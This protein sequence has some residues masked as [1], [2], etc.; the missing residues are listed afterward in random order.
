ME[1]WLGWDLS[2]YKIYY[3]RKRKKKEKIGNLSES[4]K[5]RNFTYGVSYVGNSNSYK[6]SLLEGVGMGGVYGLSSGVESGSDAGGAG[7]P[8]AGS[9]TGC[10]LGLA[11]SGSEL[12]GLEECSSFSYS[13]SGSSYSC[14]G[15]SRSGSS[16]PRPCSSPCPHL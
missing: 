11:L 16:H 6:G 3:K 10:R 5:E 9:G 14:P 8:G 12:E 4:V 2:L 1:L 15:S 7:G 13:R